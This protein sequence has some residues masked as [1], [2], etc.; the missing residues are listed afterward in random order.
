MF[1]PH[2]LYLVAVISRIS[3]ARW[4]QKNPLLC[5]SS[6]D[7]LVKVWNSHATQAL[8][9]GDMSILE[10]GEIYLIR[11]ETDQSWENQSI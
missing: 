6:Q 2:V 10:L 1:T 5:R 3:C 7:V 8:T 11:K 9:P 4:Y